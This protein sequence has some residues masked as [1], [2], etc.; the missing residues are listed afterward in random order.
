MEN[1]NKPK[2]KK[3]KRHRVKQDAVYSFCIL[4]VAFFDRLYNRTLN[5][6]WTYKC[7]SNKKYTYNQEIEN[8]NGD[9]WRYLG[10]GVIIST[11]KGTPWLYGN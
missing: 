10:N 1:V 11:H 4:L 3:A 6:K 5:R 9:T 7:K 2:L 8:V